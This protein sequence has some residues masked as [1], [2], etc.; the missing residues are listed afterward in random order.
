MLVEI[1]CVH[2]RVIN[3]SQPLDKNLNLKEKL[4]T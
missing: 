2:K 4:G 3:F 1:K